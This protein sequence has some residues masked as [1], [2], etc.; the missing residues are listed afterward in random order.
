MQ[1]KICHIIVAAGSGQRF[2][3]AL[4]KQFMPLNG[5]PVL[6]HTI[7]ALRA[8]SPDATMIV[9]LHKDF[10][11]YWKN[12][13]TESGF[14]S[15][16][17][18]TGGAT[19]SDSVRAA[20]SHPL[21][22]NADIISVHDGA[23]PLVSRATVREVINHALDEDYCGALPGSEPIDSLRMVDKDNKSVAVARSDFRCVQTPQAFPAHTLIEA[24]ENLTDD[25]MMTD[26]ASVVER[27]T[28]LSPKIVAGDPR[29]IKITHSADLRIAE[30]LID[31]NRD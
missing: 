18:V 11:D 4:P 23:R 8:A 22:R 19:R 9:V 10:I 29:N 20:L 30:L 1:P 25:C 21:S 3:S 27:Y 14:E 31:M 16:E 26:D 6:M 5:R 17:T 28:G 24:Y 2:G 7:E 12:L 13:C 15:P